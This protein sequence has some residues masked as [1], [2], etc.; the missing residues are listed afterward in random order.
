MSGERM[1]HVV[2]YRGE[3]EERDGECVDVVGIVCT[4][5]TLLQCFM[6]CDE[7][8]CASLLIYILAA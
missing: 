8:W 6:Y 5:I 3:V 4:D 7:W 2:N 1:R